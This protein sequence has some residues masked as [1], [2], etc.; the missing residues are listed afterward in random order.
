MP[1]TVLPNGALG[2]RRSERIKRIGLRK[3]T[4]E[5]DLPAGKV[6]EEGGNTQG[7]SNLWNELEVP[8]WLLT[9]PF[10]GDS[11]SDEECDEAQGAFL[12]GTY[13]PKSLLRDRDIG[14]PPLEM[15]IKTHKKRV[16]HQRAAKSK[17]NPCSTNQNRTGHRQE[18]PKSA[19]SVA[20]NKSEAQKGTKR[21]RRSRNKKP[22]GG[23]KTER[24][25]GDKKPFLF[26]FVSGLESDSSSDG[27]DLETIS[28][29]CSEMFEKIDAILR[30]SSW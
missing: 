26:D 24:K 5:E 13:L 18:E 1:E 16:V 2:M 29:R 20:R 4:V 21:K 30:R 3:Q 25:E 27:D 7:S 12:N 28:R 10:H 17:K 15:I 9:Q 14:D 8:D 23:R 19:P 6:E 11:S 22:S